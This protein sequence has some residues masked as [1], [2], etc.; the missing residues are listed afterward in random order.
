MVTKEIKYKATLKDKFLGLM[1][2]YILFLII[3]NFSGWYVSNIGNVDSFVFRFEYHIPFL[4]WMI[5]PYM[6]SGLLFGL[7][8]FMCSSRN[9]LILL[10][11]RINFITIVSGLCF[12]IFPLKY[13]FVKPE[14]ETPLL[15]LCYQFLNSWDTNYNQA[16][17]LHISYACVF[18][19][20]LRTELNGRWKTAAEVWLLIM[21]I[22]TLT[23]YQHHFIDIVAALLLV[24][25][26]FL[27]FPNNKNRNFRIQF[28]F[29]L[30][31]MLFILMALLV[32]QYISIS[33]LLI[34][35]VSLALFLVGMAYGNSNARF[36]KRKD[37]TI[38]MINTILYFPYIFTYK[39][40]RR[41]FCKNNKQP[42]REVFPHI[43]VGAML[44][45]AKLVNEFGIDDKTIVIDLS[46]EVEENKMIR[47]NSIYYSFPILDVGDASKEYVT[48]IVDLICEKYKI[49]QPGEKIHIHCLMG[50]S[51]SVYIAAM[52]I[53]RYLNISTEKAIAIVS[54]RYPEAI[55]PRY[56]SNLL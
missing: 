50:Y 6:S 18:W 45:S 17:S 24:C 14:V 46:A 34:L 2:S 53:K 22:S 42:V 4:S 12:I 33:G 26:T 28:I 5:V 32:Y 3:Y 10:T 13:S 36:L 15:N 43:F 48:S 35:W 41:F 54:E 9:Q 44:Y 38:S 39:I 49:L 16:P 37:G 11:K 1:A 51:R 55:F 25:V 40:M 23:I 31:G 29:F 20:I 30:S 7:V 27:V 8:F 19:S 52:F 56:F 47:Q 21:S